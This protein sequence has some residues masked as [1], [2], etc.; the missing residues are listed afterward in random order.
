MQL[1]SDKDLWS[2]L[3]QAEED[4]EEI[5]LHSIISPMNG[6]YQSFEKSSRTLQTVS[7]E[8]Q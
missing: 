3:S 4:G 6:L 2:V 7:K 5:E 8:A 1:F